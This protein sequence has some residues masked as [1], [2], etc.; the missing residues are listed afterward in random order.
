MVASISYKNV[1]IVVDKMNFALIVLLSCLAI[2]SSFAPRG[3]H[4][5][6]VS[7]STKRYLFG[8]PEPPKNNAPA[9]KEGGGLFGMGGGMMDKMKQAQDM[10]KEAEKLNRELL[11]TVVMGQDEKGQVFATFNGMAQPVGLKISD[12]MLEQGS[13]AVSLAATQAMIDAHTKAQAAMVQKMQAAYG[14]LSGLMGKG[15]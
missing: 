10:M 5:F 4:S 11:E 12:S 7:S 1:F 6:G 8:N 13:E 15:P 9:K 14:P 2:A 3:T